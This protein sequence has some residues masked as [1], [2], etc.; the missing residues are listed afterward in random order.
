MVPLLWIRMEE[1]EYRRNLL[2]RGGMTKERR[3][4]NT[5]SF[6]SSLDLEFQFLGLGI[7]FLLEELRGAQGE[8]LG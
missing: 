1:E 8:I 6:A 4:T 5:S 7:G 2:Q 3:R